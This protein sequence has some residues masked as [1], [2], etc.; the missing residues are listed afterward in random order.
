MSN[1]ENFKYKFS[2]KPKDTKELLNQIGDEFKP[3]VTDE[4][5]LDD[6]PE[7]SRRR[8]LALMGASAAFAATAC[9]DYRDKG[10]IV[11]YNKKPE[12]VTMGKANYYASTLDN[13][14]G[15]L[16]KTREGRPVKIDGNPEHPINKGKI[17][18]RGQASLM[19]LYDPDRIRFPQMYDESTLEFDRFFKKKTKWDVID[20]KI[21]E[22]LENAVAKNKEI[23]LFTKNS[24]SP[25]FL[26]L[27]SDFKAK[28]P[29]TKVYSH[30][31]INDT[32]RDAAWK[33]CYGSKKYPGID[34]SKANI[35]VTFESDILGNDGNTVD[36]TQ[37]ISSRRNH[38]KLNEFNRMYA[39]EG[40]FSLTGA[41]ADYRLRL[42]PEAHLELILALANQ[43]SNGSVPGISAYKVDNIASKYNLNKE[44]LKHLVEDLQKNKGKAVV[45]VGTIHS[46]ETHIAANLLNEILGAGE[47]YLSKHNTSTMANSS[48]KE[49]ESLVASMNAGNVEVFIS[50]EANP[51]F[52]LPADY[53]FKD[54]LKKVP[55]VIAM[56]QLENETTAHA[57]FLLPINHASESWGDFGGRV[58]VLSLRQP[59]ISP[60]HDTRQKEALLL[61]W[62]QGAD[63]YSEDNYHKYLMKRWQDEEYPKIAK[64]G[65]FDKFWY[66]ALH[67]GFVTYNP[68]MGE[69]EHPQIQFNYDAV[70]KLKPISKSGF[71][72]VLANSLIGDGSA[73]NN[74]WLQE[75]PHPV[76]KVV[77]DNY[78]AVS[79]GTA[80]KL[81]LKDNDLIDIDVNGRKQ[82][83]PVW[84]QSGTADDLVY[85]EIGYGREKAG[86]IGSAVGFNVNQLMSKKSGLSDRIF[87]GAKVTKAEGEYKL[88]ATQEHHA[89]DEEFVKDF[90]KIRD[91]IQE[92]TV[93][94]YKENPHFLHAHKHEV[95]SITP[96]INYPD[97][98][99]AMAMDLNRCTGCS[100]CVAACNVENNVPIVGKEETSK[101]REMHWMRI[102]R[103]YSGTPD[104]P[105]ASI[106][107]MICQHCDN[108]PCE[109]VCPVVATT[110]SPD[111]L[112]QMVYNRCVG[113][114]YCANNCPYKVRRFNFFDF[115]EMFE[116]G[117]QYADSLKLMN[118]PEVTVRSRGVMEKCTFCVQRISEARQVAAENGEEF[119]GVGITTAC[120]DAC[121]ADAIVFG[122]VNDPESKISK[123][124]KHD[125][126]YH[127]MEM[128]NVR[129]NVTYL[130]KLRNKHTNG[131]HGEH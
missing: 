69:G 4:F 108:A 38:E 40:G 52:D 81:N 51:S 105:E 35:I 109:N 124:A 11:N 22:K 8:F 79:P 1:K 58:G 111:G 113:T 75:I 48:N 88:V 63:K 67:D 117:Y 47:L 17:D 46:K 130:A 78:A 42:T 66:S 19:D 96:D 83:L 10:E 14:L 112:N 114:R 70:R 56:T 90:H 7:K 62:I 45:S 85:T 12:E 73:A 107:P 24:S 106:Q 104:E 82:T 100:L 127:V 84:V 23:A 28:Y 41:N 97:E 103:Y 101:G 120:Q 119:K 77:W 59:V 110:H 5:K 131:G 33:E 86:T 53:G 116:E 122:N 21:I 98:K 125:L 118:N 18:A 61:T 44:T 87:T 89:L 13:G 57:G 20:K 26:K 129:P 126:G 121:P 60:I 2:N 16:I 94:Q 93:E 49:I 64:I 102:D 74:G 6:M 50:V 34:F 95:I 76:S 43:I 37:A 31:I 65:S 55:E 39:I 36:Q 99:W 29:T 92:G 30:D 128:L 3:G 72:V 91:I 54:A 115:R 80:K 27:L 25:T 123:L 68:Q 32:A 9:T 71:T 15:I